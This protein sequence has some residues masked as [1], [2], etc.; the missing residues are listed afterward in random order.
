MPKT[1]KQRQRSP[2]MQARAKLLAAIGARG[3]ASSNIWLARSF[4]ASGRLVLT[5]DA[6]FM[7]FVLLEFAPDVESFDLHPK[8]E[9]V[10][11]HDQPQT[12]CFDALVDFVDG[13]RECRDLV[14]DDEER[15]GA[16]LLQRE[17]RVSAARR[18]GASWVRIPIEKLKTQEHAFWNGV[19][20]LRAMTAAHGY[21]QTQFRNAMV[22][23][24]S[25]CGELTLDELLRAFDPHDSPLAESAL[26][27]LLSERYIAI[28][29]TRGPLTLSTP[30]RW[31]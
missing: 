10:R 9:K 13:H 7:H 29:L 14:A 5:S 25:H 17:I 22:S 3:D 18:V 11:V 30:V 2:A 19:R 20:M 8:E 12:V 16:A 23:R 21:A 27:H 6:A 28:D 31:L 15:D 1:D 24:L 26:Y 4:R